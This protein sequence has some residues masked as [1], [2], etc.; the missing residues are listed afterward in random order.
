MAILKKGDTV[1]A[2][3]L[4]LISLGVALFYQ[5][6]WMSVNNDKIF[7]KWVLIF[8][9]VVYF[10]W[11]LC[12]RTFP[13]KFQLS[14]FYINLILLLGLPPVALYLG[15]FKL[16]IASFILPIL[17]WLLFI[18]VK[19]LKKWKAL[20]TYQMIIAMLVFF[21]GA[22]AYQSTAL[23]IQDGCGSILLDL[24]EPAISDSSLQPDIYFVLLDA[25]TSF[26]S[27]KKYWDYEDSTIL[28]EY[29]SLG[30]QNV[31]DAKSVY[32]Q[33]P[34]SLTST[35][36]MSMLHEVVISSETEYLKKLIPCIK[37]AKLFR[38]LDKL[39]YTIHNNSIFDALNKKSL[40]NYGL[41]SAYSTYFKVMLR[42]NTPAMIIN[43]LKRKNVNHKNNIFK[44]LPEDHENALINLKE[45]FESDNVDPEFVYTHLMLP[46][47]PYYVDQ[48]G[49][50]IAD[51]DSVFP[52]ETELKKYMYLQQFRYIHD[53][54]LKIFRSRKVNRPFIVVIQGDHGFRELN[55][56][57]D[58]NERYSIAYLIKTEG[59]DAIQLDSAKLSVNTFKVVL[60]NYFGTK[61]EYTD[62]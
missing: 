53:R 24:G 32:D 26:E 20:V 54:L 5:A 19:R 45:Q 27:L 8:P 50:R 46:H 7:S 44:H 29:K 14:N 38:T 28:K 3:S 4:L 58:G 22:F 43:F 41:Q 47:H 60:N 13:K 31:I 6:E 36:N 1:S 37:E 59:L 21:F 55:N 11:K 39:G 42:N 49:N 23:R 57:H 33:T 10:G 51:L 17:A 61:L 34:L 40:Y 12:E 48:Y 2:I 56:E 25:Q 35:L 62:R 30:F 18:N 15:G 16:A 9:I 52:M